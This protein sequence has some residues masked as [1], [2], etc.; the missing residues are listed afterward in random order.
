M[1]ARPTRAHRA[2]VHGLYCLSGAVSLVYQVAWFRI[3]VDR[4]GSTT[5][6]FALVVTNFIGGL[7][8]GALISRR[9]SAWVSSRLGAA[10]RLRVYGVLELCVAAAAL[11][12]LALGAIPADLWGT[13]PY[14]L[15]DGIFQHGIAYRLSRIL[16]ITLCVAIPCLFMGMTFPLLCS[17]FEEESRFPSALY[18]WNTGGACAGILAFE[19]ALLPVLGHSRA[20]ELA[21]ALNACIGLAFLAI[22][23]G[24]RPVSPAPEKTAGGS[25]RANEGVSVL[26]AGA[27]IGGLLTGVVEADVFKHIRY[28]GFRSEAAMPLISFWAILSI[29]LGSWTVRALPRLGLR[30]IAILYVFA[31]AYYALVWRH[32]PALDEAIM[33]WQH[34]GVDPQAL[35]DQTQ[36]IGFYVRHS[37]PLGLLVFLGLTIFPPFY[38]LS[39]LLPAVCN[40]LQGARRHLGRAYGLN[41]VA[42]CIG[43]VGFTWVAPRVN[44]FYSFK[45]A[46]VVLA[47]ATGLLLLLGTRRRRVTLWKPLLAVAAVVAGCAFTPRDFDRSLFPADSP[48]AT[49]RIRAIRSNGDTTTFVVI[50]RNGDYSLYFDNFNMSGTGMSGQLYMRLMAHFPLLAQSDPRAAAVICFGVGNT[51]SAVARH[52]S[53]ERIDI[54]DLNDQVFHTASE[55]AATNHRVHRDPRVRLIHDDGRNFLALTDQHYDLITSEPPPPTHEGVYRLYSLEYYNAVADRLTPNGM[56][57]Q[58]LPTRQMP[59]RSI[60]LAITSF[61]EAFPHSLLF[62]GHRYDF[63]LLGSKAPIDLATLERRFEAAE[64]ELREELAKLHVNRPINLL[65]RIVKSDQQLRAEYAGLPVISDERRDWAYARFDFANPPRIRYDPIQ[66]LGHLDAERLENSALLAKTLTHAGLLRSFVQDFPLSTLTGL[67]GESVGAVRL[68]DAD[69]NRIYR[70]NRR[71]AELSARGRRHEAIALYRESL[72]LA[73]EQLHILRTM[74]QLQT[75]VLDHRAAA[76]SWRRWL[77]ILPDE[78]AGYMALGGALVR[79]GDTDAAIAAW[80]AASDRSSDDFAAQSTLGRWLFEVGAWEAAARAWERALAAAP[81]AAEARAIGRELREARNRA[82]QGPSPTPR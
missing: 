75:E 35:G 37:D 78:A 47:A 26:I 70:L 46:L 24:G 7:G 2:L 28:T 20:F 61:I 34:R 32:A 81:G 54:I 67:T 52:A 16:I 27:V 6:T 4:F 80:S 62:V 40:Q 42:F 73:D 45:L 57:T 11:L 39:L 56:M 25:K 64:P 65:A 30:T 53:I 66:L 59:D 50:D 72:E 13:F 77:E 1:D 10:S 43:M 14:E 76:D 68:H 48:A 71:A 33:R 3:F 49:G 21:I 60:Q 44:A 29:F 19:F 17:A 51:A 12:T 58:W 15:R 5:L 8:L 82:R 36:F 74:A 41:T 63:I 9:V 79:L 55:F 69:W 31:I 18:A 23:R 22:G 38:L